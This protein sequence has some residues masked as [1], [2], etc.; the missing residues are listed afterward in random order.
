MREPSMT[1]PE[2]EFVLL[3]NSDPREGG[4]SKLASTKILAIRTPGQSRSLSLLP[5][6]RSCRVEHTLIRTAGRRGVPSEPDHA[7]SS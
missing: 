6:R 3:I 2:C 1:Q 7:F 4:L 5:L